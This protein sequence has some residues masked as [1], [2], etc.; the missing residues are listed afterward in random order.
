MDDSCYFIKLFHLIFVKRNIYLLNSLKAKT[1]LQTK[2]IY[3]AKRYEYTVLSLL[4]KS[5][6][7]SF[8]M[9]RKHF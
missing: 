5:E 2:I 8:K 6:K 3:K 4:N 7:I 9:Q 1:I